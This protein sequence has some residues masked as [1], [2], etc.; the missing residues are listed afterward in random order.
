MNNSPKNLLCIQGSYSLWTRL[1]AILVPIIYFVIAIQVVYAHAGLV[2]SSPADGEILEQPPRQ[3]I[4]RFNQELD[5]QSS[6]LRVFDAGGKQVDQGDG[7]VDLNDIEHKSMVVSLLPDLP[8]GEYTVRWEAASMEDGD[9][10]QGEFTFVV[11]GEE[12]T[13]NT[14][15]E[16]PR[17]PSTNSNWVI[18]VFAAGLA[19]IVLLIAS[20]VRRQGSASLR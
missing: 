12:T 8:A 18:P 7:G 9:P 19:F 2:D 14:M 10:T 3:V 20:F 16:A 6:S 13:A 4:A 17:T 15:D 1:F 11:D 5:S